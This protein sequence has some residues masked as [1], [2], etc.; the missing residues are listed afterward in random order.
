MERLLVRIDAGEE[1]RRR[2]TR[3]VRVAI[4]LDHGVVRERDRL[5]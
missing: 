4:T 1:R 2:I 3:G 5:E